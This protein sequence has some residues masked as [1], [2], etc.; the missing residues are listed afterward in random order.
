MRKWEAVFGSGAQ[1]LRA[2]DTST[3]PARNVRDGMPSEVGDSQHFV[4]QGGHQEQVD[5]GENTRHLLRDL[6]PQAIG[7]HEIHCGKKPRLTEDV[8]PGVGH[9]NL[10]LVDF[11]AEREFFEAAAASAKRIRLSES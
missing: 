3:K 1:S 10:E 11:A 2:S 7:L 8:G 9:L 5:L 6:A 4:A